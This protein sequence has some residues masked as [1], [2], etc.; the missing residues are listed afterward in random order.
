MLTEGQQLWIR[1]FHW[2]QCPDSTHSLDTE[3][4]KCKAYLSGTWTKNTRYFDRHVD[5][6]TSSTLYQFNNV[7]VNMFGSNVNIFLTPSALCRV[8]IS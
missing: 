2:L 7:L 3:M 6:S 5:D 4:M 8:T 1:F